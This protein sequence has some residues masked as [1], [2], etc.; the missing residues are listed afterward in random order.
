MQIQIIGTES[1]GVRGLCCVVKTKEHKI[2]IDPGVALGYRRSGFLPHPF[3]VAVGERVKEKIAEALKD[4]TDIV[5]SHFHGDHIPLVNANPYQLDAH[6]IIEYLMKPR[7]W[8]KGEKGISSLM[9]KRRNRLSGL[10]KRSLP[11]AEGKEDRIFK[12]SESFF[13]G[14]PKGGMGTVMMT[15]IEEEK[16]FVHASDIQLLDPR[17]VSQILKW[18]PDTVLVSGPPLYLK[19]LSKGKEEN[20]WNNAMNLS[21]DVPTLIMDHHLLR[22]QEGYDWLRKMNSVSANKVICAADFLN[23]KP[24]LLEAQ[25]KLLYKELPVP[26]NWHKEYSK[27][28]A[29]TSRYR[30]WRGY[31]VEQI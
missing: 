22:S 4:S 5:I 27:G 26:H 28:K 1:L 25:R 24:F 12:F 7:L 21:K 16:V 10:L 30:V 2:V 13:H 9:K 8:C 11:D 14:E 29:H 23:K 15:C 6:K 17:A 31:D 19:R 20:A 18:N 3:Q